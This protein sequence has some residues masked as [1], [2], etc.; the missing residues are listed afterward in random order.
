MSH[1]DS[2]AAHTLAEETRQRNEAAT[3]AAAAQKR[4]KL[5]AIFGGVVAIA[6]IGYGTYWYL[7]GS[8]YVETDNAYTATEVATVT[9]A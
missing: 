1:S 8:R 7:I 4:K 9:P 5:F 2:Q 6:A 3:K